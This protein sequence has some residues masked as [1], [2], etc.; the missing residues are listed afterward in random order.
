[1]EPV[2]NDIGWNEDFMSDM[3]GCRI[4]GLCFILCWPVNLEQVNTFT[5][6]ITCVYVA[7]YFHLIQC[8]HVHENNIYGKMCFKS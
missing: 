2:T 7:L 8:M 3:S 1:M 5:I 4:N 6:C